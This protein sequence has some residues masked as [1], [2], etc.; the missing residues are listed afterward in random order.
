MDRGRRHVTFET[1]Q[2]PNSPKFP[3]ILDSEAKDDLYSDASVST[4]FVDTLC[5]AVSESRARD[6]ARSI[7]LTLSMLQLAS[8]RDC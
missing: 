6:A 7:D 1:P 3:S 4:G 5:L 8:H 2:L